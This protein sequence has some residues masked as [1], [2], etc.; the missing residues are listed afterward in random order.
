[1][2]TASMHFS[3][4]LPFVSLVEAFDHTLRRTPEEASIQRSRAHLDKN[5]RHGQ[6]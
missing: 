1:M 4:P 3:G 2:P 5:P 6:G